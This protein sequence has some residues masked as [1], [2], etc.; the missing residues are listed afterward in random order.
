MHEGEIQYKGMLRLL[1]STR[2]LGCEIDTKQGTLREP[3]ALAPCDD[4]DILAT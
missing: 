3:S 1:Q 2:V 4:N